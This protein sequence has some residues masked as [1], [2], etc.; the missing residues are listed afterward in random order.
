MTMNLKLHT[1]F[2]A[3]ALAALIAGAGVLCA[4]QAVAAQDKAADVKAIRS[5]LPKSKPVVKKIVIDNDDVDPAGVEPDVRNS[6]VDEYDCELGNKLAVYK[7]SGE[8]DAIALRWRSHLHRLTRVS[9]T[10]GAQRFENTANGLTWITIP[11]KGLL[12]NGQKGRQLANECVLRKKTEIKT[13]ATVA[14]SNRTA[15]GVAAADAAPLGEAN[16]DAAPV[17]AP[18]APVPAPASGTAE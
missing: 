2:S 10:T 11:A 13:D 4:Q 1:L 18:A 7:N 12:L 14:P 6:E 8:G 15:G 3:R 16:T 17:A 5:K 9:T